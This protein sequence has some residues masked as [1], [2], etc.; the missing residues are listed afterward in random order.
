MNP[1]DVMDLYNGKVVKGNRNALFL[2]DDGRKRFFPDF[3]TFI[4]MGYNV[5]SV[6]K[7][8]DEI[9]NQIPLGPQVVKIQAPPPFRPE[10][11]M[12]HTQCEDTDRMVSDLGVVQSMGNYFRYSNVMRRIRAKNHVDIVALGGSI[13]AGG[14]FEE[15]K[16]HLVERSR[17]N[18]TV[19][20]H[21]H[22]ATEITCRSMR[23]CACNNILMDIILCHHDVPLYC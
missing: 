18:V 20:N 14:Y 22:G 4:T 8:D 19:H 5:T 17:L 9:L 7:I 21:G 13:T 10:D 15:F 6:L 1:Q 11:Y 16:R 12:Y 23:W 3:Y 2:L